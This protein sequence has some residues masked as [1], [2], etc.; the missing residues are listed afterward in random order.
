VKSLPV[1]ALLLA[2]AIA[3]TTGTSRS[4]EPELERVVCQPGQ[5][6]AD[7]IDLRDVYNQDDVEPGILPEGDLMGWAAYTTDGAR[8]LLTNRATANLTVFNVTTMRAET[9]FDV[10]S[11]PAGI[12]VTDSFA[13]IARSFADSVTIVRLSDWSVAARLPSGVQPWVVHVSPDQSKAYVACDISNTCEVYDLATLAHVA[14][15]ADFPVFLSTYSWNSENGRWT[16]SFSDFAV[17]PDG[18][19]LIAADG[20]DTLFWIDAATGAK[21]DTITGIGACRAVNLSGDGTRA[22]LTNGA[23]PCV[24]WQVDLAARAIT[25]SVTITGYSQSMS[26]NAAVNQDGSKAYIGTSNNTSTLIRFATS[27]FVNFGQ[28]YT[29]FWVGVAGD[30]SKAI[31]GN[32]RF[33]I[34]D[35]ATET[36]TG[37]HA[38]NAQSNGAVSPVGSSVVAFDAHRHEGLYF[39]DFASPTPTYRGTTVTGAEPEADCPRRIAITP[40]GWKAVCTNVLSDNASIIDLGTGAVTAI[41]PVGD[42]AQDVAITSD[43]RWAVACGFNANSVTVIDLDANEVAAVVPAGSGPGAIAIGP[44]DTLAWVGNIGSND[45]SVIRLAGASSYRITD[46]PCGEIGVVWANYGVSSGIATAPDGRHTIVAVSFDDVVR[47]IDNATRTV[48]AVLTVGDFPLGCAFDAT[49]EYAVVT[50]YFANSYSIL[51]IDGANSEVVGTFGAGAGPLR[52]AYD[53]VD[54][55]FGIVTITAKTL[56]CVNPRTGAINST[57]GFSTYGSPVDVRFDGDGNAIVLT[58]ATATDYGHVHR[59]PDHAVLPGPPAG[60][61]YSLYTDRAVVPMVGPDYVTVL[62]WPMGTAEQHPVGRPPLSF[63]LSPNPCRGDLCLT[64][65][66]PLPPASRVSIYN[67]AGRRVASRLLGR[68]GNGRLAIDLTALPAGLYVARLT[69]GAR[70]A[71]APFVVAR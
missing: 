11:H 12:A 65:S 69:A 28:T 45:V 35:F 60:L 63:T 13:V 38:G 46:I 49:G 9:T 67:S 19:S 57:E 39:Y 24:A 56:V 3:A 20:V 17:S 32:F 10:G 58:A 1:L 48:V 64:A 59:G 22:V 30:H 36:M 71:T 68:R 37:Q 42:R 16:A 52:A 33:S 25:G 8:I 62:T 15:L 66:A 2:A 14:S 51:H 43:S 31:S 18:S 61:D 6:L 5:T 44:G 27:D 23:T 41:L 53:P 40:D 7:F 70:S 26:Y 29:A 50:N 55:E 54:D 4:G 47:V 34:I 21:T